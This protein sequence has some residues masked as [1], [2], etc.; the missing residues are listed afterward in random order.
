MDF[1]PSS[2]GFGRG[3]KRQCFPPTPGQPNQILTAFV[4]GH[5]PTDRLSGEGCGAGGTC[6]GL[7]WLTPGILG[8]ALWGRGSANDSPWAAPVSVTQKKTSK[9]DFLT[10]ENDAKFAFHVPEWSGVGM[11]PRPL[12]SVLSRANDKVPQRLGGMGPRCCLPFTEKKQ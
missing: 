8:T 11:Q 5:L 4:G 12:G 6:L 7:F 1:P 9:E 3:T 2:R 10:R